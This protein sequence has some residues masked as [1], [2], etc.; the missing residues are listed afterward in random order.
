[1]AIINQNIEFWSGDDFEI[2]M[3]VTDAGG[4]PLDLT[5][6]TVRWGLASAYDP[7]EVLLTKSSA[8]SGEIAITNMTGGLCKV[9]LT[10]VDTSAF[11][12]EP[13]IQEAEV[14]EPSGNSVTIM[15]GSV[16]INIAV[17]Y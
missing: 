3:A 11:G 12:G 4:D 17:L 14:I 6:S 2:D 10:S 8:N 9:L 5:G 15:T 16:F 13:Y 7:R 1:M